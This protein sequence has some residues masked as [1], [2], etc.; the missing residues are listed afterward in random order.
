MVSLLS[1]SSHLFRGWS[2]LEIRVA[3]LDKPYPRILRSNQ[4]ADV[5][6]LSVQ[7]ESE[8]DDPAPDSFIDQQNLQG[9][10]YL[11]L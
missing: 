9:F 1:L 7:S 3:G 6:S 4:H 11:R 5:I 2:N 8:S 10:S